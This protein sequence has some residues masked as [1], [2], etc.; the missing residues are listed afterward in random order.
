MMSTVQAVIKPHAV[1]IY[2]A[3][4]FIISWGG[5]FLVLGPGGFP[6]SAGEFENLGLLFYFAV[7]AGPCVAGILVTVTVDGRSGLRELLARLGRWRVAPTWYA[8]AVLPALVLTA[9]ALLLPLVSSD[10]RPALLDS[11]DK[12]GIGA[13]GLTAHGFSRPLPSMSRD[14]PGLLAGLQPRSCRLRAG[15]GARWCR[16]APREFAAPSPGPAPFLC[17]SS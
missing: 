1:L 3:L 8:V 13:S 5:G 9:T 2:F 10:F 15:S 7:L 14:H 12:A 6:P 11:T 4:V 16:D 17:V